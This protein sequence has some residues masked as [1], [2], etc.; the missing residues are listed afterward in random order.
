V[1]RLRPTIETQVQA[2]PHRALRLVDEGDRVAAE[3]ATVGVD[4]AYTANSDPRELV[5]EL[6]DGRCMVIRPEAK[7]LNR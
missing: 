7:D 2:T 4:H 3:I 5:V 6:S 1:P